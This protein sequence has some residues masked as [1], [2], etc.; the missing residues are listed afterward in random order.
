MPP[1]FVYET[2]KVTDEAKGGMDIMT[3]KLP[4]YQK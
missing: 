2:M 4:I 3:R 1:V